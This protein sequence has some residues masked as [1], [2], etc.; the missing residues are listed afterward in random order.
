MDD[1]IGTIHKVRMLTGGGG[2]GGGSASS[3]KRMF[4]I[5]LTFFPI[6][7]AGRGQKTP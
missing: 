6:Q 1:T 5:K 2:W 3:Q 4:S 7:K